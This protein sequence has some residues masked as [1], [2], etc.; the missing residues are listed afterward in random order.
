MLG[1]HE[2]TD[3]AAGAAAMSV[4][5][6]YVEETVIGQFAQSGPSVLRSFQEESSPLQ[7]TSAGPQS[8]VSG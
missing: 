3:I 8:L 2:Q 1:W 4:A 7:T 5:E 6:E